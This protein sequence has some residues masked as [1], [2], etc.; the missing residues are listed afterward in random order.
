LQARTGIVGETMDTERPPAAH[1]FEAEL[2]VIGIN[3]FVSVPAPVL[4]AVFDAAGK[5]TGPIP[6]CGIVNDAPY[7]QSL[8]RYRGAWR[9]YVNTTMLKDSPRRVGER[10]SLTIAH[11]PV[12]RAAPASPEFDRALAENAAAKAVFDALTPSRQREIVRYIA[13]LKASAS[14]D[15]NVAR[16]IAFLTGEGRFI[17]SDKP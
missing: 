12:G 8:V 15:R 4:E 2:E 10:L 11:D 5:R 9:L 3:P 16:A 17:G 1:Q 13:A 14:V 6:I 7:R